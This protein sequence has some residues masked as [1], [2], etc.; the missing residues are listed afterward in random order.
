MLINMRLPEKADEGEEEKSM[1]KAIEDMCASAR[2]K[3]KLEGKLEGKIEG[4]NE[5]RIEGKLEGIR[6][7]VEILKKLGHKRDTII[8]MLK[9]QFSLSEEEVVEYL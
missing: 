8:E 1:C 3:G 9:V 4:R 6:G 5:G 2:E 7:T